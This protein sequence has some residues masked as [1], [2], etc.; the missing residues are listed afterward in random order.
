MLL[1]N[2]KWNHMIKLCDYK[3]IKNIFELFVFV[4]ILNILFEKKI[5]SL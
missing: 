3:I 5:E 2:D 1:D 4:P